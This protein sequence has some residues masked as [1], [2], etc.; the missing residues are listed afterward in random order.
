MSTI[1]EDFATNLTATL[2]AIAGSLIYTDIE[3]MHA[4][5]RLQKDQMDKVVLAFHEKALSMAGSTSERLAMFVPELA[6]KQADST[7]VITTRAGELGV[8]QAESTANIAFTAAQT[9]TEVQR[10]D[11]IVRQ[12]DGFGDNVAIE[13]AK[14]ITEAIGMIQGGGNEAPAEFMT[15][16]TSSIALLPTRI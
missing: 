12:K 9:E 6:I 13:R 3:A 11:L 2:N 16:W 10:K 5:G 14:I 1:I 4:D 7:S 8:K 15:E